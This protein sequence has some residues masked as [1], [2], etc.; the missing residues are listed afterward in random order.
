[1]FGSTHPRISTGSRL[2]RYGTIGLVCGTGPLL[3]AVA[4]AH[5]RGDLNP[6]PIGPGILAGLTIWPSLICLI[7]GLVKLLRER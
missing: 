6:N 7:V 2:V 3:V 4:V 5:F 1:M